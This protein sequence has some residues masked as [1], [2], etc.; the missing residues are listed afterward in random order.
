MKE[1][2]LRT[3][4]LVSI[5][6]MIYQGIANSDLGIV[7][8]LTHQNGNSWAG[9]FSTSLLFAGSGLMSM[10][11]RYIGKYSFGRCFFVGSLGFTL[12]IGMGLIFMKLGFSTTVMIL[13]FVL[14]FIAGCLCSVFY[15]TQFNYINI[16]SKIDNKEIKYFGINMGLAQSSNIFGNLFSSMLIKPLGQFTSVMIMEIVIFCTSLTFLFFPNPKHE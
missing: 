11:N 14:S 4:I 2:Y 7:S 10:Y 15:N 1:R 3:V 9:P 8:E 5:A 6:I 12:F 16:L 13:I